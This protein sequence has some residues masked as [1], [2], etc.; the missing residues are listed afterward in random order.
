MLSPPIVWLP[1][2]GDLVPLVRL[3][4]RSETEWPK[5]R[6]SPPRRSGEGGPADVESP[7][8]RSRQLGLDG[9]LDP[10]HDEHAFGGPAMRGLDPDVFVLHLH[11]HVPR[12]VLD[13]LPLA[14]I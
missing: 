6:R 14:V 10:A 5:N 2:A 3:L 7:G 8:V 12:S 11:R 9:S 1:R 4:Y 13:H